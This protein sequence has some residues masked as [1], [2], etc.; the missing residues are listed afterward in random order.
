[1][2]LPLPKLTPEQYL[3]IEREAEYKSEYLNGEMY[4]MAGGSGTHNELSARIIGALVGRLDGRGCKVYTSDMKV[5]A[6]ADDLYTYPDVTVACGQPVFADRQR[7]VL[8]NPKL[9]FEVLSKSTEAKD[10]S[11]KFQ[12]YKM[13]ASLEEYVLVS[14]HES[15]VERYSRR[16]GAAWTDYSEA[17]GIGAILQLSSLLIEIPLAEIYRD[18]SFEAD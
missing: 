14:Q 5:R 10:R 3:A 2:A 4:A 9:L 15:L 7:D 13:I 17:R 8:L 11:F 18:V 1:M 6:G 12:Q 16:A